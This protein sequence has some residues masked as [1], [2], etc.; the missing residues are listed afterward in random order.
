MVTLSQ[1]AIPPSTFVS[2]GGDAD[3]LDGVVTLSDNRT[4]TATFNLPGPAP[5]VTTH[6]TNQT[7]RA[8]GTAIFTAAASGNP[9]PTVQW[10]V[11]TNNGSTWNYANGA[12]STTYAFT[13]TAADHGKRFRAVFTNSAE[14]VTTTPAILTVRSVSGSDFNGDATTDLALFRPAGG[15]WLVRNQPSV[16]LGQPGDVPVPGDYNG[17]G[18]TDIAVFRPSTGQWLVRNQ[19]TVQFGD[20]GDV[21]VPGDYNGDG[22]TDIAVYRPLTGQWLV[23]NQSFTVQFGGAGYIPIAGDFNGDGSDDIAVFQPKT[24][25]WS[26]RN[27]FNRAVRRAGRR[28]GARRLQRRRLGRC[29]GVSPGDGA[30]VRAQPVRGVVRQ[31]GRPADAA[32]LQR[33]RH[34]RHRG[35]SPR[36]GPVVRA[37]PVHRPV[38]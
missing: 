5:T 3:C 22:T 9:A 20:P 27:Q 34:D 4:C 21:P 10:Q 23:R 30:V 14:Q 36:H 6:P 16:Q 35:L 32:R 8:G 7:V 18:T 24:G 13:A 26:V 29:G 28:A 33:R 1:T 31:P 25:T 15:M 38:R 11:S 2:F 37:Q 12:T 17:D 19:P